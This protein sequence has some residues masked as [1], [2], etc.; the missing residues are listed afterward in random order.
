MSCCVVL[1]RV[2]SCSAELCVV[3][4]CLAVLGLWALGCVRVGVLGRTRAR[5]EGAGERSGAEQS[6]EAMWFDLEDRKDERRYDW[7]RN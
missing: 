3:P 5:R 1:C 7:D 6:E 4:P 2:V